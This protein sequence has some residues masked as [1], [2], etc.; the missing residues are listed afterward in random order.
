LRSVAIDVWQAGADANLAITDVVVREP[1]FL[2][3][4]VRREYINSLIISNS[5]KRGIWGSSDNGATW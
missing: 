1:S 4:S 5:Q 2:L 3:A